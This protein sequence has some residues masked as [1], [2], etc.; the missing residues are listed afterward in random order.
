MMAI[1]TFAPVSVKL[2]SE[3]SRGGRVAVLFDHV[4]GAGEDSGRNCDA[5][6]PC[7]LEVDEELDIAR[8]YDG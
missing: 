4:V 6:R 7:G 5:K 3:E 8:L 1:A 2:P